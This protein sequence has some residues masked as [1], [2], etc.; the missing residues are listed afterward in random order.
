MSSPDWRRTANNDF[1]E[2]LASDEDLDN[3]VLSCPPCHR[4]KGR[5]THA[6]DPISGTTVALFNPRRDNWRAH[7]AIDRVQA[8]FVLVGLTPIGRATVDRLGMNDEHA[9]QA[10]LFWAFAGLFPP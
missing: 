7:F 2:D 6:I 9:I 10:R 3:L 5:A 4:R 8:A 1:D